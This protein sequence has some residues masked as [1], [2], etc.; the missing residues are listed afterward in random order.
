MMRGEI[1]EFK[2]GAQKV[3]NKD[4]KAKVRSLSAL[5]VILPKKILEQS[6]LAG[7][8]HTCKHAHAHWQI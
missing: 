4:T 2:T 5:S 8:G 7:K 3:E 1:S 6:C